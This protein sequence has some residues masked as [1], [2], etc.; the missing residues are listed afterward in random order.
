MKR[1][2]LL[3][4]SVALL[5]GCT[6]VQDAIDRF[7]TP[8]TATLN[9]YTVER[10]G[11][12]NPTGNVDLNVSALDGSGEPID[13]EITTGAVTVLVRQNPAARNALSP[14]Q[15]SPAQVYTGTATVKVDIELEEVISAIIDI[16][17]SGSMKTTDPERKRVDAAKAF[18]N[19]TKEQDRVAVMTFSG[20]G[21]GLRASTLLQNFTSDKAL[22]GTAIDK[23]GQRLETPIWDS[24][25]DTLDVHADD[26]GG[27]AGASRVVVLFTDGQRNGGTANFSD[28]LAAAQETDVKFFTI[29]LGA[30]PKEI[31]LTELQALAAATG[32]TFANVDSADELDT[33]FEKVFNAIRASGTITLGITPTPPAGSLVTGTVEFTVNG[34]T[35]NL[36]YAVQL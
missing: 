22:L 32:G 1:F 31:D 8:S 15:L 10:D 2:A 14:T 17:Q 11:A 6:Q 19:R 7:I 20:A 36:P 26:P 27:I 30:G 23:V 16:D 35:F 18:V 25:L 29:G 21:E 34:R 4:V 12:G 24:T 3:A 28:A 9:G 33:L 5:G 13:G